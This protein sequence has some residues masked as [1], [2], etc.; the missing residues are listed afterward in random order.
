MRGAVLTKDEAIDC[1]RRIAAGEKKVATSVSMSSSH[2][3]YYLKKH[4]LFERKHLS[5]EEKCYIIEQHLSGKSVRH[6]SVTSQ[7][8]PQVVHQCNQY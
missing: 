2:L 1:A 5:C 8:N 6:I 3:A 4:S 7:I